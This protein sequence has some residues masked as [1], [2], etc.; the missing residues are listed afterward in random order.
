MLASVL[1][2]YEEEMSPRK[3][4]L[5]KEQSRLRILSRELGHIAMAELTAEMV[6]GFVDERLESVVSDTVRKELGTLSQVF[7][8]AR[9]LWK[10]NLRE[11]PVTVAREILSVTKTLQAGK[12]RIRR[13][14][15]GEYRA[16]LTHCSPF[17]RLLIRFALETGM[18]RGELANAKHKDISRGIIYIPETKTDQ[19]RSIPLSKAAKR[20]IPLLPIQQDGSLFGIKADRMTKL[21][22]EAR[23]AAGIEDLRFHDLRHEA[24]SRLF[25]KGLAI[26][27]VAAISGHSDWRTLKRYTHVLSGELARKIA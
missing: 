17:A 9:V 20:V 2:R 21:F 26:Q 19:P 23:N 3:S 1:S 6:V 18:R 5:A 8:T 11:N 12:Q 14:E 15:D 27:E 10:I 24:I 25:E 13:F 4:S 22:I 16:L 7:K